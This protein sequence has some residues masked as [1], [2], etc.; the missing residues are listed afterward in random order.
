MGYMMN[1]LIIALVFVIC[2]N[3]FLLVQAR[4]TLWN[5]AELR[6]QNR[7]D[8]KT[9]GLHTPTPVDC[10]LGPWSL[11]T[12]CSPCHGTTYK[13]RY[14]QQP[15]KFSGMECTGVQWNEK[16]C[17]TMKKCSEVHTCGEGE[18]MCEETGRCIN[19]RLRCNGDIDCRDQSDEEGCDEREEGDYDF[20]KKLFPIPGS[21]NV[22]RGYNILTQEYAFNT[23][24]PKYYGGFCD[25]VYNGDWRELRYNSVCERLY[26]NDDEKYYRKPYNFHSYRFMAQADS[27][28]SSEYYDDVS[29]LLDAK[30]N[31]FSFHASG[32]VGIYIFEGGMSIQGEYMS[33]KNISEYTKKNVGFVRMVTKV[34]TAQFKMRS[35]GLVL[36]EEMYQTLMEL[37][38]E[39]NYGM[40]SKFISNYGTHYI[41]E[42]TMGGVLEY[43]LVVD[44]EV[45]RKS[46]M[47]GYQIGGCFG[48][49]IGLTMPMQETS[50]ESKLSV[51][52]NICH[53]YGSMNNAASSSNS[54]ILDVIPQIRGGDIRSSGG[55][56]GVF[57]EK[58]YRH[59][60][61]SLKYSPD[62]IDFEILPIYELLR[63]SNVGSIDV[64][65]DNMKRAWTDYLREFSPCRCGPCQNN[66]MP[67]LSGSKCKCI[68]L[69]GYAG[70]ACEETKRTGPMHG[71]WSCW[72][73][74]SDCRSGTMTRTRE[75][76]NP[77]PSN[78]GTRCLGRNTQTA[79]C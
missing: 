56:L 62:L 58:S 44:K 68:C 42:G 61:K 22:V 48:L 74:W 39:Y 66:G 73:Q 71:G 53:K 27:G 28:F 52:G 35:S 6:G 29:G 69:Q 65:I 12:S 17:S 30:K 79:P 15:S 64:K 23:L 1:T 59:W 5:G 72:T 77:A 25:Y 14:L 26:Y 21:E 18:F 38:D 36:D 33:L 16:S 32:T 78:G 4:N 54:H 45:M 50:V 10:S 60:G 8:R 63:F 7:T 31:E 37:P 40:Y 57:D 43:I 76:N 11:W 24:D 2:L 67:L 55:L 13:H 70:E 47:N 41:T 51:K 49:S 34:Q 46:E 20:C 3:H 19:T 75:C 9:R